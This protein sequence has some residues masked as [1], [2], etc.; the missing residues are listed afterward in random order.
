MQGHVVGFVTLDL[1]LWL[2][3]AR[4]VDIPFVD[5][6]LSVHFDDSSTNTSGL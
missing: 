6:I 2:F 1:I 5:N 3:L 4:M